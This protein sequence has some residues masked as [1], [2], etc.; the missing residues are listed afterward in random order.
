MRASEIKRKLEVGDTIVRGGTKQ[1]IG[2]ILSQDY[3]KDEDAAKY[4]LKDKSYIEI[5]FKD[6][7]GVYDSWK[8]NIDGG[9][10]IYKNHNTKCKDK[11]S[12]MLFKQGKTVGE[13][14]DVLIKEG[15][16]RSEIY[17]CMVDVLGDMCFRD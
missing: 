7:K 13:I 8:S 4:G 12:D 10:I 9:S 1:I 17:Q 3:Y 6:T 5:E 14:N 2:E 11:F 15:Y 16:K